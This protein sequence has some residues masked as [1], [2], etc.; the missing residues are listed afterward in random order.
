MTHNNK[1]KKRRIKHKTSPGI[2][3]ADTINDIFC[4]NISLYLKNKDILHFS[5]TSKIFNSLCN[6]ELLWKNRYLSDFGNLYIEEDYKAQY[7]AAYLERHLH[8]THSP[9]AREKLAQHIKQYDK[10]WTLYYHGVLAT[11]N[12]ADHALKA[13]AAGSFDAAILFFDICRSNTESGN[14]NDPNELIQLVELLMSKKTG[15]NDRLINKFI[16]LLYTILAS[17]AATQF[18]EETYKALAWQ[19]F[20]ELHHP[21]GTNVTEFLNLATDF[22]DG[23][24]IQKA[25]TTELIFSSQRF[26]LTGN[27][28]EAAMVYAD[29]AKSRTMSNYFFNWIKELAHAKNAAANYHYGERLRRL[30]LIDMNH[31]GL[32]L[33]SPD[34]DERMK[35]AMSY[36][37]QAFDLGDYRS[38]CTDIHGQ[39]D[40]GLR[41]LLSLK[42]EAGL[43]SDSDMTDLLDIGARHGNNNC[44]TIRAIHAQQQYKPKLNNVYAMWILQLSACMNDE[45]N[46]HHYQFLVNQ[47]YY[48][49]PE[50]TLYLHCALTFVYALRNSD[51][52]TAKDQ[53]NW[54]ASID[55]SLFMKYVEK[56]RAYHLCDARHEAVIKRLNLAAEPTLT[57]ESDDD[58]PVIKMR[59]S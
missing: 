43:M 11:S 8:N 17:C 29:I 27:I 54:L 14:E 23:L 55:A 20:A 19:L 42:P 44:V 1:N 9:D 38:V 34:V 46:D 26:S 58:Y 50:T 2:N 59:M 4:F 7:I 24:D 52:K 22:F 36:Y 21:D 16:C 13:I 51:D 49:S 45:V 53:Y 40:G 18:D 39:F 25:K 56:G 32:M 6:D 5:T 41:A 57:K 10:P 15:F 37:K 48:R 30:I 35:E 33:D 12:F 28:L 3:L 47:A 31:H